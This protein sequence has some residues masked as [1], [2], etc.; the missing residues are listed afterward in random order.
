MRARAQVSLKACLACTEAKFVSR[1]GGQVSAVISNRRLTVLYDA[2]HL[3]YASL[4]TLRP[5]KQV[6]DKSPKRQ[7]R[8]AG[9]PA[10]QGAP[11]AFPADPGTVRQPSPRPLGPWPEQQGTVPEEAPPPGSC[12]GPHVS[13]SHCLCQ[14]GD[15]KFPFLKDA[16]YIKK[17]MF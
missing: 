16:Y 15:F 17:K 1:P 6:S 7:N 8:P 10:A 11:V 3:Y 9:S 2:A 13:V 12:P 14:A 4:C 5:M